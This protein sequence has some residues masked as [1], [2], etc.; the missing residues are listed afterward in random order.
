MDSRNDIVIDFMSADDICGMPLR[1]AVKIIGL[2]RS[3]QI[4]YPSSNRV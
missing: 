1:R 4:G 2:N 3:A